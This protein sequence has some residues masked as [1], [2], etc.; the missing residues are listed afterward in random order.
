M[1][2]FRDIKFNV[3]RKNFF[4]VLLFNTVIAVFTT[5]TIGSELGFFDNLIFSQCMGI[6]IFT[7]VYIAL[8]ILRTERPS[9][10]LIVIVSA[11][12][13]GS[14]AGAVLGTTALGISPFSLLNE[15]FKL[16][17]QMILFGLLFGLIISYIFISLE[18]ISA[19]KVKRL[20]LEKTAAEIELK[21]LQ[22]QMEPHFL[23]NT[24][25]NI[26]GLIDP[27]PEKAK[28]MLESFTSF[29]RASL[30]MARSETITLSQEME[31]VKN[32]LDLFAV[33]MGDRLRYTIDI[34][35]NV[36]DVRIPPLFLQPLVENAIKHGLEP[37]V[38]GGE[39]LIQGTRV[40]N[41][42]RLI[43]ADSGMGVS[44]MSPGAGIGLENIR[45]RLDLFYH[46]RGT[47]IFEE[48]KPSGTK[49]IIEI[50]YETDT[51]H[52]S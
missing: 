39:L 14:A 18:N 4:V 34:P 20:D 33:R 1:I 46:G 10:V 25:S 22:S 48:N 35:G 7:S 9:F 37:S 21:L 36:R 45:K 2:I 29:L 16:F 52:H 5:A 12:I 15:K 19:E 49:A 30:V 40:G 41:S 23:F 27:H 38:R 24:L 47:M 43:V 32:Y 13:I 6:S 51:S 42:V 44:A 8:A 28:R 26:L 31:V 11:I 17:F 50:P 3:V